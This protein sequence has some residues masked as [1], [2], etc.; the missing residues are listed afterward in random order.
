MRAGKRAALRAEAGVRRMADAV[1]R[2]SERFSTRWASR[3]DVDDAGSSPLWIVGHRGAP[4]KVVENTL[5]SCARAVDKEGANALE[6]DVC[7]TSDGVPVLWHDWDPNDTVALARQLGVEPGVRYAPTA[8]RIWE[9]ERCFVDELSLEQLRRCYGYSRKV[10]FFFQW[11]V[12]AHIPTFAEFVEWARTRSKLKAVFLDLKVPKDRAEFAVPLVRAM[13]Q[14]LAAH[15]ASFRAVWMTPHTEVFAAIQAVAPDIDLC[16][17]TELPPGIVRDPSRYSA[18]ARAQQL[19]SCVAAVGRPV[20]TWS[21]WSI[22]QQ[23]VADDMKSLAEGDA[24]AAKI[25]LLAW[26][27]DSRSESRRMMELGVHGILTNRPARLLR[28]AKKAKRHLA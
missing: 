7:L 4:Y 14:V 20:L 6:I 22:Y 10:L 11:R 5:E 16:L 26:T 3:S 8:P 13:Q 28:L 15:S 25:D 27:F 24:N 1:R 19:N 2:F 12:S 21:G 17:D 9:D 18:V 23:L